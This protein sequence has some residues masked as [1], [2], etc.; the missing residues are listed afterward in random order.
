LKPSLNNPEKPRILFLFSDTG[1]GHRSAA[2]AIIEAI[3][4]EYPGQVDCAMVDILKHYAPPPI[5]RAPQ[6]YPPLS[7]HLTLW[8]SGYRLS[9]GRR[10]TRVFYD[11]IWPYIR[12]RL[13]RLFDEH[14]SDL[15]V[16]VHQLINVPVARLAED[17]GLPFVT[18]VTDMVTTHAAWYAPRARHIIVPTTEAF[19]RGLKNG[20]RPNQMTVVGMPVADRFCRPQG[21]RKQIRADLAW[22]NER[23]V[24]LMVGGGEGMGPLEAMAE[25][26]DNSELDLSLAVICGRNKT[27]KANLEKRRW[28][29]PAHIYGFVTEMPKFMHA[30]DILVTKAGPGT[31]SEAFIA[32]LP[33]VLY[34]RMPGQEDGNVTYVQETNSGV[35]APE[36]NQMVAAVRK[37]LEY[38]L[39]WARSSEQ[40]LAL[41]RPHA[42]REIARILIGQI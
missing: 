16:S 41:A 20:M 6:I 36:P 1:G 2:E 26:L 15:L 13:G 39:E 17:R 21:D 33:M 29:V 24:V 4:L 25:A 37:W 5:N 42:A 9:D 22:G 28:R 38:P 31:I 40:C 35:W 11:A 7:R 14:P 19:R 32:G 27:L 18:V 34:S 30:A 10:R 12:R 3:H 8:G 23:P